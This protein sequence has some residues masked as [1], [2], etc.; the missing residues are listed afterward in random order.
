M[1][2]V[3]AFCRIVS[4]LFV[5][6]MFL[7]LVPIP[8]GNFAWGTVPEW[9][10]AFALL[11]ITAAVWRMAFPSDPQKRLTGDEGMD[12]AQLTRRRLGHPRH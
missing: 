7:V 12:L 9:I 8:W 2:D 1:S 10:C 4:L 11:A 3:K 6:L 5:F